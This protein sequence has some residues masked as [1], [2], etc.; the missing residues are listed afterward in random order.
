MRNYENFAKK[1]E[2]KYIFN[3]SDNIRKDKMYSQHKMLILAPIH[4]KK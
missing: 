1:Q 2:K 4:S 3:K